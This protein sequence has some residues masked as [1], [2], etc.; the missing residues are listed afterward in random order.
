[1]ELRQ[2]RY[3]VAVAEELH[4][5]RAAERL[6]IVQPAVSQQVRRLERELG[7]R[8]FDRTP[9]RVRLT[10]EG[11]DLLPEARAVLAAAERVELTAAALAADRPRLLRIGTGPGI[12][13]GLAL[14]LEELRRIAPGLHVELD[15]RPAARQQDA[16]R[17]GELDAALV[18]A[19]SG[20][21]GLAALEV[22]RE[23]LLAALPADHPAAA[24]AAV[25]P[26]ELT[27]LPLRLP[28][29]DTDPLLRDLVLR[30]CRAAGVDPRLGR[31]AGTVADTLVEIGA[32]PP[33]WTVVYGEPPATPPYR[34]A[35]LPFAPAL[36]VPVALVLSATRPPHCV[37]ALRAAFTAPDVVA[38]PRFPA[39]APAPDQGRSRERVQPPPVAAV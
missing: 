23:P 39:Q 36:S 24:R 16:V 29:A 34:T 11:R 6:H 14:G 18:R 15:A 3:F 30:A 32:G 27:G 12:G 19:A 1:M 5:G 21:P 10:P 25:D 8:L 13:A 35:V 31:P 28:A 33:A 22:W 37:R 2:L 4:F 9:R 38:G 7:L 26:A 17:S 20:G